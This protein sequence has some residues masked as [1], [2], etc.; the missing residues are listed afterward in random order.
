MLVSELISKLNGFTYW[1]T[2]D[3]D[4]LE[5]ISD[6]ELANN[7]YEVEEVTTINN[8]IYIYCKKVLTKY[9]KRL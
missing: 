6:I 1:S 5:Y 2:I 9:K 3:N 4:T 7:N 8:I